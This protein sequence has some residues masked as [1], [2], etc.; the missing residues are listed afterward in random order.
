M[1]LML[2]EPHKLNNPCPPLISNKRYSGEQELMN[3]AW[4]T[5]G[6]IDVKDIVSCRILPIPTYLS[7]HKKM[8]T[9][10]APRT[11]HNGASIN[12]Q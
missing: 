11:L 4:T 6:E 8:A 10:C 9:R 2:I 5:R 1:K 7:T 12:I 3:K